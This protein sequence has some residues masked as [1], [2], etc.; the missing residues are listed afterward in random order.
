MMKKRMP[1]DADIANLL[2]AW[3]P[4]STYRQAIL[5]ENPRL[6]YGFD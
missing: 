5:V 4:D 2:L 6:L 1:N 3:V